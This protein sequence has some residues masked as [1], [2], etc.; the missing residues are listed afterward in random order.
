MRRDGVTV[1]DDFAHHPTAVAAS[2]AAARARFPGRRLLAVFE[3]RT[4]TSRRKV[5]Q[6]R[7]A[8]VF[9]GAER[10][11]GARRIPTHRSTAP[12]VR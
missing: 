3:P 8:E 4:N 1:L 10:V 6:Q 12:P 7:Y 5:F 11:S 2:I 9:D